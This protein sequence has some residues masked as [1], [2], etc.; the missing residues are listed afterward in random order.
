MPLTT[1]AAMREG[2]RLTCGVLR[3]SAKPKADTIMKR[4]DP[5]PTKAWVRNPA[6]RDLQQG[7]EPPASAHGDW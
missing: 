2:S 6:A 5:T 1:C 3:M 4:A 7:V